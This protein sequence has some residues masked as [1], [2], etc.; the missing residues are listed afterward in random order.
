M[1]IDGVRVLV[2]RPGAAAEVFDLGLTE[3]T[4]LD[5]P[6]GWPANWTRAGS[7]LELAQLGVARRPAAPDSRD[8][9]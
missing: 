9:R 7:R 5:Q 8:P 2:E 4:D 3:G 6:S 1:G